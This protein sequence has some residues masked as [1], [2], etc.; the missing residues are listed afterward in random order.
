MEA[1]SSRGFI[2]LVPYK[3]QDRLR[4]FQMNSIADPYRL[5]QGPWSV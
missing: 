4:V 3:N 2:T 1:L 5:I